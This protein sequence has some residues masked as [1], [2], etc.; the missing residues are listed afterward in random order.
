MTSSAERG[1]VLIVDD[2]EAI[3]E[4]LVLQA[5]S[6]DLDYIEAEDG[7]EALDTLRSQEF[8]VIISDIMMP[9]LTGVELLQVLREEGR[10]IP[11]ILVTGQAGV[12]ATVQ[13]L[14]LGAFDY[15]EKPFNIDEI[16]RLLFEAIKLNRQNK[17]LKAKAESGDDIDLDE[18]T[19]S[20]LDASVEADGNAADAALGIAGA[21][22]STDLSEELLSLNPDDEPEIEAFDLDIFSAETVPQ[23]T[24]CTGSIEALVDKGN[25]AQEA[26]YLFRTMQAIR[27]SA[28]NLK[29]AQVTKL[30][31]RLEDCFVAIRIHAKPL[32][33]KDTELLK[34]GLALLIYEVENCESDADPDIPEHAERIPGWI[35]EFY[36][37]IH[38]PLT[39][40]EQ[41]AS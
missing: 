38:V 15:L 8:D 6:M 24:F 20:D 19:A 33:A 31:Q 7:K 22:D 40:R 18:Q 26:G 16:E 11:V 1:K 29:L 13:A 30:T 36:A 5:E 17:S 25:V 23:L 9:H 4:I 14:R 21:S 10:D 41:E 32:S 39:G 12:D 37:R 3:R 34:G 28:E 35:D 27:T 2:E